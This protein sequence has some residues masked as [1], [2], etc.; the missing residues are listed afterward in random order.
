MKTNMLSLKNINDNN[1]D[2]PDSIEKL[3]LSH[4]LRTRGLKLNDNKTELMTRLV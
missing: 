2:D 4:D 1:E 3:T